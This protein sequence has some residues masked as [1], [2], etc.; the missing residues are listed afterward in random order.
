[1]TDKTFPRLRLFAAGAAAR[2]THAF[3]IAEIVVSLAILMAGIVGIVSFF[4]TTLRHNQRAMDSSIAAYLAQLKAEEIRR[5]QNS[6]ISGVN[7]IDVIRARTAPMAP[8]A[9]I[10]FPPDPRFAYSFYGQSLLDPKEPSSARVI[11]GYSAKFR[12]RPKVLVSGDTEILFE[13]VFQ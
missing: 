1:M 12:P 8:T 5:D 6:D 13:L 3:S 10:T 2:A 9:P 7:L 11:V 4:P